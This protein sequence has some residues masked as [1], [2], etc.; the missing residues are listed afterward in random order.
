MDWYGWVLVVVI[1]IGVMAFLAVGVRRRR[2]R[3]AVVAV[4]ARPTGGRRLRRR[5]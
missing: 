2:R 1:V 3:G 5:A 4:D